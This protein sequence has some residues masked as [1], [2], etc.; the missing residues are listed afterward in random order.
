LVVLGEVVVA[1]GI[2]VGVGVDCDEGGG[3]DGVL[4]AGVE[5]EELDIETGV[6]TFVEADPVSVVIRI[7]SDE[8]FEQLASVVKRTRRIRGEVM[9]KDIV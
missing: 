8:V 2:G 9:C 4:G 5:V 6:V 7:V 1:D 3:V